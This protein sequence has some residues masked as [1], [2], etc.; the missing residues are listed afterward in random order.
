MS[1][2]NRNSFAGKMFLGLGCVAMLTMLVAMARP[3]AP[4]PAVAASDQNAEMNGP[5]I[6]NA[7]R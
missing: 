4:A 5:S 2:L 7:A 3:F 1:F 6:V